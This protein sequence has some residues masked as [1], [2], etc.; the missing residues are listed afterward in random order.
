MIIFPRTDLASGLQLHMKEMSGEQALSIAH[1]SVEMH[2][3]RLT[4][5]L[6]YVLGDL[7]IP[8]SLTVQERYY[9]LIQYLSGQA[10]TDLETSTDYSKYVRV[11]DRRWQARFAIEDITVH[12]LKGFQAELLQEC[13]ENISDWV[14][15]A[16]CMQVESPEFGLLPTSDNKTEW[17]Q[18]LH[19]RLPLLLAKPQ[20]ELVRLHHLFNIANA[21]M[22]QYV[23][24]SFDEKGIVILGGADDAPMRFCASTA[25]TGVFD[26]LARAFATYGTTTGDRHGHEPERSPE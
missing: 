24:Y 6:G 14:F 7:N 16:M 23:S 1:L 8:Y 22:L 25:L 4:A 5:F 9:L 3:H 17:A 12:Q 26:A 15:G 2:E 19:D 11:S 10:D 21:S 20:S 18:L 13:S